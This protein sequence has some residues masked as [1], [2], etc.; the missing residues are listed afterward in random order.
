MF[1]HWV[2]HIPV[3][4]SVSDLPAAAPSA[5]PA[6]PPASVCLLCR[7]SC[8][9]VSSTGCWAEWTSS[10]CSDCCGALQSASPALPEQKCTL[11]LCQ[12]CDG[13]SVF[14]FLKR[15]AA[16]YLNQSV[17]PDLVSLHLPL[18]RLVSLQ[19]SEDVGGVAVR[20]VLRHLK[21]L[22]HPQ[23]QLICISLELLQH[24]KNIT[25]LQYFEVSTTQKHL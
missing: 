24:K 25:L 17:Q 15:W 23:Q 4:L 3:G 21:L 10:W 9:E 6:V 14:L 16:V 13:S 20:L 11:T 1:S 18:S 12:L 22:L 2:S 5:A 8:P 7:P 19:L